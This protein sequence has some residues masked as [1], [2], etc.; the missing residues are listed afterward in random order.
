MDLMVVLL[1]LGI[2]LVA[3]LQLV[4]GKEDDHSSKSLLAHSKG[5][6]AA[7]KGLCT[8]GEAIYQQ[9]QQYV[10][11]CTN[12]KFTDTIPLTH[13]PQATQVLIFTGN[14]LPELMWNILGDPADGNGW[15]NGPRLLRVMDLSNNEI[16]DIPG[17]AFHHV[18]SVERLILNHNNIVLSKHKNHPRVFSNFINLKE[19]HLTDAFADPG[20]LDEDDDEDSDED[21]EDSD[22]DGDEDDEEK[23]PNGGPSP[24]YLVQLEEIFKA[25][26]LS[27]LEK[28]HLEQNEIE[29]F[30]DIPE[31]F[32]TLPSLADLHLGNNKI[33]GLAGLNLSCLPH[34]RFLDLEKNSIEYLPKETLDSWDLVMAERL[35]PVGN[36]TTEPFFMVDL[37]G[38]P[39]ACDDCEKITPLKHWLQKTQVSIRNKDFLACHHLQ[40][41]HCPSQVHVPVSASKTSPDETHSSIA[42]ALTV[43]L[44]LSI[45]ALAIGA[46]YLN[47][48]WINTKMSPVIQTV[49]RKVQYTTIGRQEDEVREIN[50]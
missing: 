44:C 32:C 14:L 15:N 26:N 40:D 8:C 37:G 11:N 17:K 48:T 10:V 50:V 3:S 31:L 41:I 12:A 21:D 46:A 6:P 49:T 27:K 35:K 19:L 9:K 16:R 39:F 30:T 36:R 34:L 25:S 7:F 13:L 43:F 42:V 22:E 38:N 20:D 29:T 23:L 24:S 5:C 1:V 2:L 28:L 4:G 47:R 33:S 18:S 45:I